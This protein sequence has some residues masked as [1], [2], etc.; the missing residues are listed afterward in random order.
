MRM[1]RLDIPL[2]YSAAKRF[3]RYASLYDVDQCT[4]AKT[5]VTRYCKQIPPA[6]ELEENTEEGR[7]R[8]FVSMPDTAMRLLELLSETTGI[9]R[10]KLLGWAIQKLIKDDMEEKEE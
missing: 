6:M 9:S 3:R 4:I 5:A 7:E 1:E 8:V 2:P 10:R